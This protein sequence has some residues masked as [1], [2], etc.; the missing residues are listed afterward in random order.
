MSANEQP[1]VTLG[2]RIQN[3]THQVES[4]GE[5]GSVGYS[6]RFAAV[7]E[8]LEALHSLSDGA[9]IH[10]VL[11]LH[12]LLTGGETLL[13][14]VGTWRKRRRERKEKRREE[15]KNEREGEERVAEM[16]KGISFF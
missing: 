4:S 16:V 9:Q 1:E 5:D 13:K 7:Q 14:T 6:S 11:V 2:R 12:G 3:D 8:K 15:K 10:H